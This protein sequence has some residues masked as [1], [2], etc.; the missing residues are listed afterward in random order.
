[1]TR[2]DGNEYSVCYRSA[3]LRR[4]K[5]VDED[6]AGTALVPDGARGNVAGFTKLGFQG[7]NTE[8]AVCPPL[9]E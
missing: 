8:E 1:M 7:R 2:M 6:E 4:K 5:R 3:A 9:A